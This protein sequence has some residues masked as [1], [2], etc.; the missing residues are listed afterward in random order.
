MQCMFTPVSYVPDRLQVM[1][2]GTGS[3][4]TIVSDMTF[5]FLEDTSNRFGFQVPLPVLSCLFR[6]CIAVFRPVHRK[7]LYGRPSG[8][9]HHRHR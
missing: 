2:Y 1:S 8:G 9:I 6:V 7:L 5:A 3:G 4:E